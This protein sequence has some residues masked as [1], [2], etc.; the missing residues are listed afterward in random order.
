MASVR[1]TARS[2]D[3]VLIL[4]DEPASALDPELVEVCLRQDDGSCDIRNSVWLGCRR[5]V[6]FMGDG[7]LSL[8]MAGRVLRR[9]IRIATALWTT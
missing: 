7:A 5:H 2:E 4:L 6:I 9:R 3:P 8:K 1:L